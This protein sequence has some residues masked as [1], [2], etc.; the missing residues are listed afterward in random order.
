MQY[1]ELGNTGLKISTVGFGLW[2]VTTT[3]WG[4]TDDGVGIGLLRRAHEWGVNFFDTADTYGDG[5]G[6]T[7]LAYALG[8]KRDGII[9]A[10]KF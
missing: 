10:T 8:Q 4:I 2:T 6:E 9:I 1:R 5:N 7:L 3:W